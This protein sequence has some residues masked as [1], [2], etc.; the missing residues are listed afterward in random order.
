MKDVNMTIG[1]FQPFTRGH[2]QMVL[3]G[4]KKNGLPA[5][6]LMIQN[7]KPDARH[8]F[9]DSLVKKEID[10]L[11][12]HY[13]IEDVILVSNADI[14]KA[15]QTLNESGYTAHLWLC[16]D[17]REAAYKK[18]AENPKYREQGSY[19]EDFTTYT[20]TGRIEGVSGTAAREA[21]A[22]SDLKAYKKV[23]PEGTDRL[24]SAFQE[25]MLEINESSEDAD[26]LDSNTMDN[27]SKESETPIK[28]LSEYLQETL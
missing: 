20:G 11:K 25:E 16:G 8:P 7:K 14:V 27:G 19:P 23:M 4:E 21:I 28:K 1:R 5:V 3:D 9:S 17:D 22:T 24:F 2:L 13:P 26:P 12:K 6:V 15:G 18:Q 10:L